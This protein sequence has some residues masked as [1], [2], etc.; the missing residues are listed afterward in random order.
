MLSLIIIC[1]IAGAVGAILQGMVGIG[2]GLV[3]IPLLSFLLPTY[4]F[5]AD[6]SMHIALATS[7]AAI[8]INSVSALISHQ[9]QG[10]IRWGLFKSIIGYCI[11]GAAVGAWLASYTSGHRLEVVF[12]VFMILTALYMLFRKPIL[13]ELET[14]THIS[15]PVL[16]TGG[17]SIGFVASI[18]G[19]GGGTLL[20]PFLQALKVKMRHAVGTATL[21]GLPIAMIG[22]VTYIAAG[23]LQIPN[24]AVTI[25]YLHWPAFLAISAAGVICA[26]YGARLATV[27]PA[28]LLQQIFAL[29]MILVGLK[30]V[31]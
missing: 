8:M 21:V 28:K 17:L 22:T 5:S 10:N 29:V 24:T 2:T 11:V 12:G 19:T 23:M 15:R 7:M 13:E 18:I 27:L 26:P 31:W 16:A 1:V 6:L 25:G 4:G 30:M 9:Q 20:I 14:L 3:V